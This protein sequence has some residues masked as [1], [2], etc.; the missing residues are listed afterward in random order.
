MRCALA[1]VEEVV[2]EVRL[3]PFNG[4]HIVSTQ[5]QAM[6]ASITLHC[7]GCTR[8]AHDRPG[9]PHKCCIRPFKAPC[10]RRDSRIHASEAARELTQA[11][12]RSSPQLR[13]QY[14]CEVDL[15]LA[16]LTPCEV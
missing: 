8:I 1:N 14:W 12:G 10:P 16:H 9:F 11:S 5:N 4:V 7:D 6:R 3:H 2:G 15:L 13:N